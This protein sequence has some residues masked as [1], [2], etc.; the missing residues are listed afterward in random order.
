MS[1]RN[2][3]KMKGNDNDVVCNDMHTGP[4]V[5]YVPPGMY[6]SG[7]C[8]GWLVI[9]NWIFCT[10]SYDLLYFFHVI[11]DPTDLSLWTNILQLACLQPMKFIVFPFENHFLFPIHEWTEFYL[12]LSPH[13]WVCMIDRYFSVSSKCSQ[14]TSVPMYHPIYVC[15]S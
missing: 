5:S 6:V 10:L 1:G 2:N 8:V 9:S 13:H 14:I 15:R 11:S 3:D 4:N 7:R 12:S